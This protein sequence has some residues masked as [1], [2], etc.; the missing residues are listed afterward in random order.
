MKYTEDPLLAG[1]YTIGYKVSF[2]NYPNGPV[3]K[4]AVPFTITINP[5]KST[6]LAFID[7][8][9]YVNKTYFLHDPSF[10]FYKQLDMLVSKSTSFDCGPF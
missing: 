5:C 2:A 7:P 3:I 1:F 8:V 9:P 10:E 6:T 4:Q